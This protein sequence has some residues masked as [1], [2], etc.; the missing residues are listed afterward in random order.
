MVPPEY[1]RVYE[2][3]SEPVTWQDA[4]LPVLTV[5]VSDCPA[6][7]VL[8]WAVMEIVGAEAAALGTKAVVPSSA[9]RSAG[10]EKVFT[11][12]RLFAANDSI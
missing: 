10:K 6:E 1:G 7:M 2:L 12:G 8:Y 4:A 5:R 9:R 11:G 3:P